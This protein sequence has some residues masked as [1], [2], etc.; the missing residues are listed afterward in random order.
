MKRLGIVLSIILVIGLLILGLYVRPRRLPGTAAES[1]PRN[2]VAESSLPASLPRQGQATRLDTNAR[3]GTN[4][5][6]PT[7]EEQMQ[8]ITDEINA[9][10]SFFGKVLDQNNQPIPGAT[11][12]FN[13][14]S[15][16]MIGPR[17][18]Q[19]KMTEWEKVTDADGRFSLTE[20]SGDVL[21]IEALEKPGY[22]TSPKISTAYIFSG[23]SSEELHHP[24][25]G[26]P[27]IF[28]MWKRQGADRLATADKFY[29]LAPDNR[30]YTIDLLNHRKTE[31]ETPD[32]DLRVRMKR[33]PQIEPRSKFP[34]EVTIEAVEGGL[35]ET[36][37]EMM[38]LAPE[39]GYAPRYELRMDPAEPDWVPQ[40]KKQFYLFS[41]GKLYTRFTVEFLPDYNDKS[42]FA[43]KYFLNPTGSR[44]LEF[45]ERQLLSTK[46]D[47]FPPE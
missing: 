19:T 5:S 43:I 23:R 42:V 36:K 13:T 10:M 45:D 24:D 20:A 7:F 2:A 12:R 46:E 40:L 44:N 34:W 3:T 6:M 4:K 39:K 22:E 37:D 31:G 16:I 27:V 15:A 14:R 33:P 30:I 41:R 32:G 29:G 26:N 35:I 28:R 17:S 8:A 21:C 9:P 47:H 11:V 38:N 25:V 18:S 1:T